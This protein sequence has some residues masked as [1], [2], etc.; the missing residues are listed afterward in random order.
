MDEIE[1]IGRA[2]GTSLSHHQDLFLDALLA[3]LDGFEGRGN[4]AVIAATNR[5]DLLDPALLER[6]F[7]VEISVSRPDQRGARA[8]F[9][10]HL[11]A[12]RYFSPNGNRAPG[13]RQEAIDAA[14]SAFY[15]P[16][17]DNELCV[18]RFRD[19]K[20]RTVVARELASGRVFEQVSKAAARSAV[21]R[22]IHGGDYSVR[23]TDVVD[24]AAQAINSMRSILTRRNADLS[25]LYIPDLPQDVG[26]ATIEPVRRKVSKPH[27]YLTLS[28][29]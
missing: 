4:I 13:T 11:P 28:A 23:V 15:S 9:G 20:T 14:V 7:E 6:L 5:K 10:I 12:A 16:N 17:C 18:I 29:A 22:G 19:G 1:S 2:R 25:D 26:I 3:E 8:I 21:V 24:A 27:R